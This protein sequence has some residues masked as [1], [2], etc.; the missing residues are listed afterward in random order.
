MIVHCLRKNPFPSQ[1]KIPWNSEWEE[2]LIKDNDTKENSSKGKL[3]RGLQLAS[4][5]TPPWERCDKRYGIRAGPYTCRLSSLQSSHKTEEEIEVS[6]VNGNS[7]L[8]FDSGFGLYF[9]AWT[10]FTFHYQV[11]NSPSKFSFQYP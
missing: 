6:N 7:E 9:V 11:Q 2:F 1:G 4:T 5:K 8:L 10:V 3:N